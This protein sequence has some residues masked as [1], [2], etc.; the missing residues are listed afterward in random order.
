V[1]SSITIGQP[2][3]AYNGEEEAL[4]R[5]DDIQDRLVDFAV[6]VMDLCDR[7]PKTFTGRHVGEQLMRA[8]TTGTANYAEVRGAES[9][10]DFIH[11]LGI[12][13]KE[14]NESL[15]WLRLLERRAIGPLDSI[16][17]L[18][19]ECDELCRIISASRKTAEQNTR[20]MERN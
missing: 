16:V 17:A 13:R 9:R 18:R 6:N 3:I 10:N 19:S 12:V 5:G 2:L 11:K 7:L 20:R 8:G 1:G 4:I 15:V 14:L